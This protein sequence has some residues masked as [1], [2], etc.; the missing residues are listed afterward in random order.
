VKK[1]ILTATALS[2]ACAS[3]WAQD[4]QPANKLLPSIETIVV[5]SS[6]QETPLREVATSVAVL[7]QAQIEALGFT[8]LA[9]VLRTL[10]SVSISN[11]GGMGKASSLRVRGEAGFRT[12]VQIDGVDVSDPTGTQS[13]AQIQHILSSDVGRVELLRGPQGLMYGAD[14]GGVL[15]I[16]TRQIN[17]GTKTSV[18]AETGSYNSKRG[19]ASVGGN[20]GQWDYFVS[21]SRAET[22]GF[23][24]SLLDTVLKDKDG[25]KNT[26]FHGRIGFNV[27]ENLRLEAVARDTD[28]TYEFDRCGSPRQDDCVGTFE[29]RILRVSAA[30]ST[31]YLDNS[32]A[33]SKSDITRETF[34]KGVSDY[35]T[36]GD[37]E[38]WE[39]IGKAK[40]TEAHSL[41]YGLEHR[42]DSVRHM[43]RNQKAVYLEYQG[44]YNDNIFLTGC[45]LLFVC[46][47]P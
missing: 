30:H 31:E 28:A 20:Q 38:K 29:Q 40:L 12:L 37:I 26:T 39:W 36:E 32:L 11:S 45:L 34:S 13:G 7:E 43:S 10:P 46:F 18:S 16:S 23:N 9:D 25:Y 44:R 47:Y 6:R 17:E 4:S 21:G 19:S 14:A 41:A 42:S 2:V 1:S 22:D 33:Y 27:N 24:T 15:N 5:V 35:F 8:A 3:V